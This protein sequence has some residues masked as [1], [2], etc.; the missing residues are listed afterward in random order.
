MEFNIEQRYWLAW[1]YANTYHLP[2]AWVIANEFP[3][4][5]NVDLER[6]EEWNTQNYK[7]LRYQVDTKWQKGHLPEMFAS[8]SKIIH[9][10]GKTQKEAWE[11]IP[12]NFEDQMKFATSFYKFGRYIGWF[13]LQTLKETC[14]L[15]C[16]PKTLLLSDPGSKSHMVGW[17]YA[18]GKED[19][20]D[21]KI[22]EEE[23]EWLE[24]ESNEFLNQFK[25]KYP[26]VKA[27]NFL[28]ETT[29]CAF[30]KIFRKNESR[31]L[32]YY[33]DRQ[34]EDILKVEADGWTGIDW[35]LLW[36]GRKEMLDSRLVSSNGVNKSRFGEYLE[37]GIVRNLDWFFD[38][39]KKVTS[40]EDF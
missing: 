33:L 38:D 39:E 13:Y 14:D 18:L 21:R 30:K 4:F 17:L 31:Y 35:D 27:D 7:R 34:A 8:Y 5:E 20:K 3:D 2:T 40:L 1:L 32:G 36:E 28:M 10:R 19:W 6:L 16:E 15:D 23:F 29:L 24:N 9:S 25:I 22:T 12:K 11:S 26:D 37:T